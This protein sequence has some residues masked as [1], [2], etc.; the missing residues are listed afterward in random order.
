VH[1]PKLALDSGSLGRRRSG[2]GVLVRGNERELA[3]RYVQLVTKLSLHLFQDRVKQTAGR[4]FKITKLFNVYGRVCR[5]TG[6]RGLGAGNANIRD[7]LLL[8]R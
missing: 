7:R 4:T 2:K 8:P 1:L 3:K 5:S 6:M